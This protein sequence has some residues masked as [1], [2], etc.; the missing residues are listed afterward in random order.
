MHLPA[1]PCA[2][3]NWIQKLTAQKSRYKFCELFSVGALQQIAWSQNFSNWPAKT[4]AN[5]MQGSADPEHVDFSDWS[6]A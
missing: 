3:V 4:Y 6:A 1:L 2:R 5:R